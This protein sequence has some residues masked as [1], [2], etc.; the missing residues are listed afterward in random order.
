MR[1]TFF[2]LLCV[3]LVSSYSIQV[4]SQ[5]TAQ[6]SLN[7]N[8]KIVLEE[9]SLKIQQYSVDISSLD[10]G[11]VDEVDTYFAKINESKYFKIEVLSVS[12]VNLI[13]IRRNGFW[14]VNEWNQLLET[15]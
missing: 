12:E 7:E 10:L 1:T 11:T 3:F 4:F 2:R 14:D 13:L 15:L 5:N 8:G 6:A 9:T